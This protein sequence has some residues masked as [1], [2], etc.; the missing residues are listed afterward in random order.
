MLYICIPTY[1]EAPTVGVLLWRIRKVFQAYSR[2]Y[3]VIVCDDGSTDSTAETLAPYAEVLP[4][5]VI[6]GKEH[7]GYA[8]ALDALCR[9]AS[10][11]S[12]RYAR[13][14]AVLFLQADFTDSPEHI[15]ELVKRFEGGADLVLAERDAGDVAPVSVK[16]LLRFAPLVM[17]P[18]LKVPG[19]R[20]P[21]SSFR[22]VRVAVIREM[23]K[24]SGD[25]PVV[26]GEGWAANVD[27]LLH[28]MQHT[29]RIETV[30]LPARYDVRSRESR[31]RP[32]AA[33]MSLFRYIRS[34]RRRAPAPVVT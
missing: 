27:F 17:R 31:L 4:L 15:P 32:M 29:R 13:R 22:L 33:V 19:V 23:L 2:E 26:E 14:D 16:R 21:F 3:E 34:T 6:G 18:F 9:R 10:A 30:T 11:S 28:A 25:A 7:R 5:T 12:T 24:A 20:D 8:A 1:N